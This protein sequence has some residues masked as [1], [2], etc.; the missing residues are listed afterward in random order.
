MIIGSYQFSVVL[1]HNQRTAHIV[2]GPSERLR[3]V[4]DV[5]DMSQLQCATIIPCCIR[6]GSTPWFGVVL[7]GTA[8]YLGFK[9][10]GWP[11]V[12]TL[13]VSIFITEHTYGGG[14]HPVL[15]HDG[16]LW[17]PPGQDYIYRVYYDEITWEERI[18]GCQEG[19]DDA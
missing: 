13:G 7:E 4:T 2:D 10:G 9:L 8:T 1:H 15:F 16:W 18:M 12:K 11:R 17:F 19:V 6:D 14:R 3:L 5:R